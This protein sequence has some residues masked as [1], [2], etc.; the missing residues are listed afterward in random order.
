MYTCISMYMYIFV[1][2]SL[3]VSE[4]IGGQCK[5]GSEVITTKIAIFRLRVLGGDV[6][7]YQFNTVYIGPGRTAKDGGVSDGIGDEGNLGEY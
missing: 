4:N 6:G 3:F 5:D 1:C 2:F 7:I